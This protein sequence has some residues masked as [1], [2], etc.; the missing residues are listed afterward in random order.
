MWRFSFRTGVAG[1]LKPCKPLF[2]AILALQ[3]QLKPVIF[4]KYFKPFRGFEQRKGLKSQFCLYLGALFRYIK[5]TTMSKKQKTTATPTA[6]E[7]QQKRA[8]QKSASNKQ[9]YKSL[10]LLGGVVLFTALVLF[11]LLQA[12]FVNW[13]DDIYI[14]ENPLIA[15]IGANF[16]TYFTQAMASNY[17]PLT[18]VSLAID[19]ALVGQKPFL[20]HLVNLLFHL[21]NTALVFFFIKSISKGNTEVALLVALLFGIH[22]M[23]VESVAWISE[24]K[25]V[26]FTCF[27]LLSML[28]YLRYTETNALKWWLP[29]FVF[30]AISVLSKPAAVTLPV[31]LL[32]LDWYLGRSINLKSLLEKLPFFIL[33]LVI[34]YVTVE[35]QRHTAIGSFESYTIPQRFMFAS[36]GLVMYIVKMFVPWHL[37]VLH[38]YPSTTGG[39]P[40]I[41]M[42]APAL[43]AILLAAVAWSV[44]RT[45][46]VAFGFLFYFINVAL[47][48][49]FLSVG[50]AI[51]SERYTYVPYIGLFY[52]VAMGAYFFM[53][54]KPQM[55]TAIRTTIAG[56]ALLL[57]LVT[58][59][60]TAVWQNSELLWTD[61][62]EKYPDKAPVAHNNR[63]TYYRTEKRYPEALADYNKAISLSVDYQLP[64]LN[65]GNVYFNT[66][67]NEQA[68]ADYNKA[69]E[70]KDDDAKAYCN[71]SAVYFQLNQLEKGLADATRAIE[72]QPIYPDAWMNRSVIFASLNRHEEAVADFTSYLKHKPDTPKMLNWRGI[73][74]RALKKY[75]EALADFNSAIKLDPNVGE[76]YANRS[77]AHNDLGNRAAALT[78]AQKAKSMGFKIDDAYLQGL[79]N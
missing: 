19:Y 42:L 36:Y 5:Q 35:I 17:H 48:L 16:T 9:P 58:F 45:K 43:A 47:V 60:R 30:F 24:R 70:L 2:G 7:P 57:A 12:D 34:G 78:D 55:A 65:R 41:Y 51:M 10:W 46:L 39:L 53:K 27:F 15:N 25:D 66:N 64:Y 67:Q 73:S 38:P 18:M 56:Y 14:L 72:L 71:R 69:I 49:Q 68:L 8:G 40:F 61:V 4:G 1:R 76:Y 59:N 50:M 26:L 3:L 77:Y 31:I 13:D 21:L 52:V 74:Y 62:I 32:L 75:Q 37:S 79:G 22:P 33:A 23:H 6:K 63:G 29:A 20:F 11:P 28:A 54:Q 44:K